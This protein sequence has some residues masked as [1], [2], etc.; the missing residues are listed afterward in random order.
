MQSAIDNGDDW[1]CEGFAVVETVNMG[2]V[3]HAYEAPD[4]VRLRFRS[5]RAA[6]CFTVVIL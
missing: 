4:I 2:N 6:T 1:Y 5:A 3:P